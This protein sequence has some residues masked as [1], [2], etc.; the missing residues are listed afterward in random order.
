MLRRHVKNGRRAAITRI[1]DWY[2]RGSHGL[3]KSASKVAALFRRA[4]DLGDITAMNSLG[5]AYW[6]GNGVKLDKKKAI[7]Y[8]RM[9]AESGADRGAAVAQFNLG[10]CFYNGFCYYEG[11]TQDDAE[12]FRYYKLAAD[13]GLTEAEHSL[14][15]MYASGRGVALDFAEAIRWYERAAAKGNTFAKSALVRLQSR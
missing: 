15:F 11:V 5:C 3:V 6:S 13:Q 10:A 4:A 1:G 14:G 12:A 2:K 9:A 8:W 7:K